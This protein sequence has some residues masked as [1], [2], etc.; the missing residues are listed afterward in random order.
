MCFRNL[1][2]KNAI[3]SI[4]YR[5]LMNL[6]VNENLKTKCFSNSLWKTIYCKI[7][8]KNSI[9]NSLKTLM[10][11]L[12]NSQWFT[13]Y[14]QIRY[15]FIL[16]CLCHKLYSNSFNLL[17]SFPIKVVCYFGFYPKSR[18]EDIQITRRIML[19][20]QNVFFILHNF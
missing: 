11:F 18:W 19:H 17:F 1:D 14:S 9:C 5:I 20:H 2:C 7:L 15:F 13:V 8:N 12:I 16:S 4:G 3:E 6:I 10:H